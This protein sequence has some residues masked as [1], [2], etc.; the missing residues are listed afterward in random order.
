MS[1]PLNPAARPFVFAPPP[2]SP[3]PP[4][5]DN[6]AL[7][8]DPPAASWSR[9]PTKLKE[10]IVRNVLAIIEEQETPR[11]D[12][13]RVPVT[14]GFFARKEISDKEVRLHLPLS[15]AEHTC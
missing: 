15:P 2:P 5:L 12:D 6:L 1:K 8:E 14:V 3:S 9:L 10:R 7:A 11:G 13:S 4:S